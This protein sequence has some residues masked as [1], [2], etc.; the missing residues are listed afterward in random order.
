MIEQQTSKRLRRL[1]ETAQ[2][3]CMQTDQK[4]EKKKKERNRERNK[5]EKIDTHFTL[6]DHKTYLNSCNFHYQQR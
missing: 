1:I 6:L 4:K 2:Q 5:E 3:E